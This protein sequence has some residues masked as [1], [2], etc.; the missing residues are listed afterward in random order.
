MDLVECD[1]ATF[2]ASLAAASLDTTVSYASFKGD[3]FAERLCPL[4]RHVA[5]HAT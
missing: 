1:P 2:I 4:M 3:R 5:N